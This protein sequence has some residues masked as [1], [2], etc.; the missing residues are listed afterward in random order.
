MAVHSLVGREELDAVPRGGCIVPFDMAIIIAEE[1]L[2][3]MEGNNLC[4]F[5]GVVR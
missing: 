5:F 3:E 2:W 4:V 1:F